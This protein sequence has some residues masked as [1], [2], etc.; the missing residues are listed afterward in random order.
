M[1]DV[2]MLDASMSDVSMSDGPMSDA[3]MSDAS[4]PDASVSDASASDAFKL[5]PDSVLVY[6]GTL[7]ACSPTDRLLI[8]RLD[9]ARPPGREFVLHPCGPEAE[10]PDRECS[11]AC[12]CPQDAWPRGRDTAYLLVRP[13]FVP[14]IR[15]LVDREIDRYHYVE[16]KRGWRRGRAD[17]RFTG[18]ATKESG[19]GQWQ[20]AVNGPFCCLMPPEQKSSVSRS[21]GMPSVTCL[22]NVT[23]LPD[24]T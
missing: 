9:A 5:Y 24:A 19:K 8:L 2:S 4:M 6:A 10:P 18:A 14:E 21:R 17:G 13:E 16:D 23:C 3:P 20:R 1:S 12:V 11:A 15:R 7:L 22:P